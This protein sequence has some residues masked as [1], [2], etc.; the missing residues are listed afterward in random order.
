MAVSIVFKKVIIKS[1][2]PFAL[3]ADSQFRAKPGTYRT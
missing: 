1:K 3:N 2:Q